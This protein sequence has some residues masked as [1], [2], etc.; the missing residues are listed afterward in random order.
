MEES[1]NSSVETI[2]ALEG[3]VS[4]SCD[5]ATYLMDIGE[6]S[7]ADKVLEECV[8]ILKSDMQS[9][10]PSLLYKAHYIQA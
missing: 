1:G 10:Y 6:H 5:T 3:Y 2:E 4:Q 8:L 9:N 7:D